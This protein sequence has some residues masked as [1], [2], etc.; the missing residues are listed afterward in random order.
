MQLLF[1]TELQRL[2]ISNLYAGQHPAARSY[3]S[4]VLLQPVFLA[5]LPV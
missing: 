3:F 4:Q 2:Y 1:L 5:E